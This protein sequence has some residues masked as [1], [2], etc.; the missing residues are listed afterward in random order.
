MPI[1]VTFLELTDP[2]GI[3][4]PAH[5]PRRP[6][7]LEPIEDPEVTRWFYERVGADHHWIDRLSWSAAQ[8]RERQEQGEAWM[9][10]VGGERAGFFTLRVDARPGRGRR[11]RPP[12]GVPGHR[13]RR[14]PPDRCASPRLRA[15][16]SRLAPHLHPRQ[17]ERPPELRGARDARFAASAGAAA[18]GRKKWRR[19][20]LHP[21]PRMLSRCVY[22]RAHRSLIS[23]P[24]S[25]DPWDTLPAP[26]PPTLSPSGRGSY[27]RGEPA[28]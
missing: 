18:E 13:P 23:A 22:E 20:E 2:G 4:S 3:R 8:W 16:R 24:G 5:P 10:T 7:E 1:T 11:L 27:L 14:P 17:P 15:R 26:H 21:R 12:S 19:W 28:F 25:V 6:Y 9:A